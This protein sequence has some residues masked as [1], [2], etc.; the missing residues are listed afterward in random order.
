MEKINVI[1]TKYMCLSSF[2]I[3]LFWSGVQAAPVGCREGVMEVPDVGTSLGEMSVS[4]AIFMVLP[5]QR[6]APGV[7][8]ATVDGSKHAKVAVGG[9]DFVCEYKVE[10]ACPQLGQL[11]SRIKKFKPEVGADYE[12]ELKSV[13]FGVT[14]FRFYVRGALGSKAYLSSLGSAN[15]SVKQFVESS[16]QLLE[17]CMPADVADFVNSRMK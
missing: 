16:R 5:N 1:M 12:Q 9:A 15:G 17:T 6:V 13:D 2:V 14:A 11:V 7:F 8:F 10:R 3:L 4:S